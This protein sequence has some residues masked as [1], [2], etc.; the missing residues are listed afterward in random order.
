MN[1]K[2]CSYCGTVKNVEKF[3]KDTTTKDGFSGT[4]KQCR[5]RLY[6]HHY[7]KE[8]K[9]RKDRFFYGDD[10]KD[11]LRNKQYM[12][13]RTKLFNEHGNGWWWELHKT[14]NDRYLDKNRLSRKRFAG[15]FSKEKK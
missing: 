4:C 2:R 8:V 6:A 13:D 15:K 9:D 14:P 10:V 1:Y 3:H 7:K 11:V 5:Q 12:K